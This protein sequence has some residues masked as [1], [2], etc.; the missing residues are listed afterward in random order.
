MIRRLLSVLAMIAAVPV[1]AAEARA[2]ANPK[3]IR[4]AVIGG[5]TMT[6]MWA[7]VTRM[8]EAE[9][10][11]KVEVVATGPRPG[12]VETMK[13]GKADLITMHSG[14]VTTDLQAEGYT[15]NMRPWT[16]NDL[17]I[18]GPPSDPARIA[19]MKDGAL[20]LKKIA[21]AKARFVDSEDIGAREMAHNLWNRVGIKP[22]GNWLLQDRCR[23]HDDR[24]RFVERNHAY[25]IFGR[26]P[27]MTHKIPYKSL[28]IMVQD[29]PTMRRPYIVME[30]NPERFPTA[31]WKG[32]H[33][34]ADFL[35]SDKVQGMLATFGAERNGG[36]NM[37]H[38]VK[39]VA[40]TA[41]K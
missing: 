19:G 14:D 37:F 34:L 8:F 23:E 18:V 24:L 39:Q 16:R 29:D 2:P 40:K 7:E 32:A 12:L 4:A 9:T 33:A 1:W 41:S 20:A 38:P 5:F 22:M 21:L 10:G 27:F 35:F 13:E 31:N 3:V 11:Y 36:R 6:G 26:V 30:A 17:V 15:V 28:K 25:A